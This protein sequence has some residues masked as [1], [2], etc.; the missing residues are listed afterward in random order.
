MI[1]KETVSRHESTKIRERTKRWHIIVIPEAFV[2]MF[3]LGTLRFA[4]QVNHISRQEK[5]L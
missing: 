4:A 1:P 5:H 2:C 3:L